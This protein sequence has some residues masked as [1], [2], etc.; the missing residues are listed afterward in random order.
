M[1][2][3]TIWFKICSSIKLLKLRAILMC[4][5]CV[6]REPETLLTP[7]D[8]WVDCIILWN[9]SLASTSNQKEY[10]LSESGQTFLSTIGRICL[11]HYQRM[12]LTFL[13]NRSS[14]SS[15]PQH[16]CIFPLWPTVFNFQA[17][18]WRSAIRQKNKKYRLVVWVQNT[19]VLG[20]CDNC[21]HAPMN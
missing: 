19:V 16:N 2:D 20:L 13:W 12:V 8:Y 18:F 10:A 9:K 4:H 11:Y 17:A 14:W 3:G 7:D 21:S 1:T 15:H 6:K 5:Q